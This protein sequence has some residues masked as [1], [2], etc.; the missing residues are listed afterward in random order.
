MTIRGGGACWG[1]FLAC[2][3][4]FI[5]AIRNAAL[6]YVLEAPKLLFVRIP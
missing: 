5:C 6:R 3:I 4:A 2:A 1:V